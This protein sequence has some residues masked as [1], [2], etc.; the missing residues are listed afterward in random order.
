ML[1]RQATVHRRISGADRRDS[2]S[3]LLTTIV[4]VFLLCHSTKVVTNC[5]EAYQVIYYGDLLYW[6]P[7]AEVLSRFNHLML[8]VNA[9]I[10]I[11]IYVVKVSSSVSHLTSKYFTYVNFNL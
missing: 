2:M 10:N 11:L 8:A 9:S 3:A 6:P 1:S 7:W 5:Y 4:L